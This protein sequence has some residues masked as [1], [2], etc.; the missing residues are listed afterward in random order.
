MRTQSDNFQWPENWQPDLRATLMFIVQGDE[1]LLIRKKRG[2]G[3]GKVNGPGGKFEPGETA[4][5]CVLREVKEELLI[6]VSDAQE[7]GQ[8]HFLFSDKSIPDIHGHVFMATRFTGTPTETPEA[9]PFLCPIE[10]IPYDQMWEDDIY[11]L[12]QML[13]GKHFNAY[14]T[15]TGDHMTSHSVDIK[16]S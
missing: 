3:A 10:Q 15:F 16:D 11:W 14:F 5:Q 7:M 9:A 6:D 8:L 1:V 13:K 4:L 2:I 12:P